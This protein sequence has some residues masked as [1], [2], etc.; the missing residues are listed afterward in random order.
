MKA[1]FIKDKY[2]EVISWTIGILG[3]AVTI[4]GTVITEN[5]HFFSVYIIALS[6][7]S[8]LTLLVIYHTITKYSYEK[9]VKELEEDIKLK[10][11]EIEQLEK[12]KQD[13]IDNQYSKGQKTLSSIFANYKNASKLNN[14]F[15]NRI[16]EIT[17][18]SYETLET[19]Q[20]AEIADKELLFQELSKA[21]GDFAN[22]LYDLYKRYTSNLLSYVVNLISSYL[23]F[24][25][26]NKEIA[27]SIKL[28]DM[29][30]N[31]KDDPNKVHVYTAFRD[32]RTYDEHKREIGE[33]LYTVNGNVDF[34]CCLQ[35]EQYIVNNVMKGDES[36]LNEHI[37]FDQYYN[38]AVVVPIR[39]RQVNSTYDFWGYI[40]CD[41]LNDNKEEVFTKE[42]AQI[43]FSMA[44]LY[45]TFLETLN[46]NWADRTSEIESCP[47]HFL[48]I[49]Y[50]NTYKVKKR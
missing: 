14:D 3:I 42:T 31:S 10:K 39:S 48:Q 21:S 38:C 16:P 13:D 17:E 1:S 22:A 5:E 23:H 9:R 7:E 35:K 30:L 37:D 11:K 49:I 26:C 36:Y 2:S 28:F 6:L 45:A 18:K 4:W 50:K 33:E 24:V 8:I 15:C 27:I 46:S 12:N 34:F 19:F 40:C 44:E 25:G 32:K 43:L 29:P 41:C 47:T 20:K